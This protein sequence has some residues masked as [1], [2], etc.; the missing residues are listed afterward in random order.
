MWPYKVLWG[1]PCPQATKKKAPEKGF[2]TW[3]EDTY[4][5]LIDAEPEPLISQFQVL[6]CG[7]MGS[8][9]RGQGQQ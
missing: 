6:F 1:A 2:V 9:G 8:T 5:K 7:L 4:R 3:T